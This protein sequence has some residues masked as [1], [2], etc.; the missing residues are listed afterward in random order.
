MAGTEPTENIKARHFP[1]ES[2]Y[3]A[4][5]NVIVGVFNLRVVAAV[6][7]PYVRCMTW[8]VIVRC[9]IVHRA[10][11]E[12]NTIDDE[13]IIEQ[14]MLRVACWTGNLILV[15]W[16]GNL[17]EIMRFYCSHDIRNKATLKLRSLSSILILLPKVWR[18]APV[19]ITLSYVLFGTACI[20]NA[21]LLIDTHFISCFLER[22]SYSKRGRAESIFIPVTDGVISFKWYLFLVVS[23]A[24]FWNRQTG[25]PGALLTYA[26]VFERTWLARA[27][28]T[29]M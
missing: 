11:R 25:C 27:H 1:R 7:V 5:V 8:S 22:S 6:D 10:R 13:F 15:Y 2:V 23:W 9:E 21:R 26:Y 28:L 29:E 20:A 16:T 12:S 19:V 14:N 24:C 17:P 3:W 18:R 4:E